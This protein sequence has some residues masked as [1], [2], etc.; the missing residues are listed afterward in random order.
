MKLT[1]KTKSE[2]IASAFRR[3]PFSSFSILN[4]SFF[5][6][7]LN[8][9]VSG[10]SPNQF[11]AINSLAAIVAKIFNITVIVWLH[12]YLLNR[13]SVE[14]YS[15][16]PV[17]MS[18]IVFVP[19]LTNILTSGVGRYVTEAYVDNDHAAVSQIASTMSCLLL[20]AGC[21][22]GLF[23]VFVVIYLDSLLNIPSGFLLEAQIMLGLLIF[24]MAIRLPFIPFGMGLYVKQRFVLSYSIDIC[25]E[26]FRLLLLVFLL[27]FVGPKVI[28]V[29]VA[30]V[31]TTLIQRIV[32]VT[33]SLKVML[34][35]R[36][37]FSAIKWGQSRRII[38][39]GGW[40]FISRTLDKIRSS[41][42]AIILNIFAT[43]L[44]VTNFHLGNTAFKQ[45]QRLAVNARQPLTPAL[46]AMHTKNEDGLL[47]KTYLRVG[48]Y[49]LWAS[50]FFA[51]PLFV[52][53]TQVITLYVGSEFVHA[54]TVMAL[55]LA[56]FPL[57]YGN[58]LLPGL[59][60]ARAKMRTF[61][62]NTC[63]MQTCNLALTLYLVA[64]LKMGAIGSALAT[65]ITLLVGTPLLMLPLGLKLSGVKFSEWINESFLRGIVPAFV[66][67]VVYYIIL[68][69][70]APE[71]WTALFLCG[72]AGGSIY[73]LAIYFTLSKSDQADLANILCKI[74][75][76]FRNSNS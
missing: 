15:I 64:Y 45:I 28:W 29:V 62:I 35:L 1:A 60:V 7:I 54:A 27:I 63:I 66:S 67:G 44:D 11:S 30:S 61:T 73:L 71:T 8:S 12:Q 57:A 2:K 6:T 68:K 17:V 75:K 16:Y 25:F 52:V 59:A 38:S 53:R 76:Y 72:C 5:S 10:S 19:L 18:V 58:A 36:F 14:E 26:F 37:R 20:G 34:S 49:S 74:K 3:N 40:N 22:L 23:G 47:G 39:F 48:R 65:F 42:D 13:I 33:V 9:L 70:I 69:I 21:L 41:A 4:S 32:V 51:V 46:I 24:S 31:T 50:L 56:M 55:L 43:P